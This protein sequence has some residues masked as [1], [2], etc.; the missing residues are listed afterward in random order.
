MNKNAIVQ[1][2]VEGEDE[3]KLIEV[4]KANKLVCAGKI[5]IFNPICEKLTKARLMTIKPGT[6]VVMIFDTDVGDT[7]IL[8]ENIGMMNGCSNVSK[9]HTVTQV[10]NLEDE[11]LRCCKIRKITDLFG[12]DGV[13]K[14]KS[15]F[16]KEKNLMNKLNEKGFDIQKLWIKEPDGKFKTILNMADEVKMHI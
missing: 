15:D 6:N 2:Y 12:S 1:Y 14:F 16:I 5:Q 13:K 8:Q 11:L 9:V 7:A 3:K 4:L 10:K